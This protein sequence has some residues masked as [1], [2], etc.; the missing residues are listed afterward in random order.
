MDTLICV[1]DAATLVDHIHDIKSWTYEGRIR[2]VVPLSAVVTVDQLFQKSKE[3]QP[4]REEPKRPKSGGRPVRKEY[5]TFDINPE[6][7]KEFLGRVRAGEKND[8]VDFQYTVDIQKETEQ[9]S[10][11]KYLEAEEEVNMNGGKR[12]TS[13]AQALQKQ[14]LEKIANGTPGK[15]PVKTKLVARAAGSE[16]NPWKSSK[17]VS[18]LPIGDVPKEVR[19]ILSCILWR[20][21]EKGATLWDTERT[22]LLC[23]SDQLNGLATK[24]GIGFKTYQQLRQLFS[25]TSAS[26]NDRSKFG[27]LEKEFGV[28]RSANQDDKASAEIRTEEG[29]QNLEAPHLDDDAVPNDVALDNENEEIFD[30]PAK[31]DSTQATGRTEEIVAQAESHQEVSKD[32]AEQ[33]PDESQPKDNADNEAVKAVRPRTPSGPALDPS[34]EIRQSVRG[35]LP[36]SPPTKTAKEKVQTQPAKFPPMPLHDYALGRKGGIAAWVESLVD[37]PLEN[38]DIE[39]VA[40][41]EEP[42]QTFEPLTYRQAL[43]GKTDDGN[44]TTR[45]ENDNDNS[46]IA[47]VSTSPSP[48][49]SP[50]RSP[51]AEQGADLDDSDEEVVVFNP[52]SKRLSAHQNQHPQIP[53][54]PP[55]PPPLPH[56]ISH[57]RN[58]SGNRPQSSRGKKSPSRKKSPPRP[59]VAPTIIDPDSFG[60][61]FAT[62]PQPNNPRTFSP[63]GANGRVNNHRHGNH[64]G[65]HPRPHNQRSFAQN[66]PPHAVS[67]VAPNSVPQ[68][69][70]GLQQTASE[71]LNGNLNSSQSKPLRNEQPRYSPRG[72]PRHLPV[73]TEPEFGQPF[74]LRSG[75]SRESTRGRGKLWV[76]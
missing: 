68:I 12:P 25:A 59:A 41:E 9:Y 27:S 75:V 23:D 33:I 30:P 35:I 54:G 64:R 32:V 37:E 18:T 13:F 43:T 22:I 50:T 24:L 40:P 1:I 16:T 14:S 53:A 34:Q 28:R 60:R 65:G 69:P 52:K 15:G 21:H 36:I 2:L 66:A 51:T 26:D 7:V 48:K 55:Q 72:S 46:K 70:N 19:P 10:P 71:S 73:N 44:K 20:L 6:V 8:A 63:H 45:R 67:P 61:G 29:E 56:P 47:T 5:P 76:P 17:K 4:K 42:P 3:P 31:A 58:A 74:V 49:G 57:S 62:N 38:T 11:W 39:K